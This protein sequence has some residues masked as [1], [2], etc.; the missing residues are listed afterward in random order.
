MPAGK[1]SQVGAARRN[2]HTSLAEV[3]TWAGTLVICDCA[4]LEPIHVPSSSNSSVTEISLGC[5][6]V[7]CGRNTDPMCLFHGQEG[8]Q[9]AKHH[10]PEVTGSRRTPSSL[11]K[12]FSHIVGFWKFDWKECGFWN[13]TGGI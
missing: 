13:Q 6:G 10:E 8:K 7:P 11:R 2:S 9:E 1:A 3:T 12:G 5:S 4:F